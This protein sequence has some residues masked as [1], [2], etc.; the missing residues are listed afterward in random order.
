MLSSA[1]VICVCSR[2][3]RTTKGSV[4][5]EL[6]AGINSLVI[7]GLQTPNCIRQTVFDDVALDYQPVTV[8]VDATAAAP[9][10]H[11]ANIFDMKNIGVT[12]TTLVLDLSSN[13]DSLLLDI[14]AP[15]R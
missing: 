15:L 14:K 10:I 12:T 9:D 4:G 6:G 7:T 8:L 3:S 5:A 2:D 1:V 11:V 13:R